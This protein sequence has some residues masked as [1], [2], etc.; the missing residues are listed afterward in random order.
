M[1][2]KSASS[3]RGEEEEGVAVDS[4]SCSAEGLTRPVESSLSWR[5]SG[6]G[7]SG[8]ADLLSVLFSFCGEGGREGRHAVQVS[9][10]VVC[11]C[12][13]P[14]ETES[15]FSAFEM[16]IDPYRAVS[17]FTGENN[18]DTHINYAYW[19]L[20]MT[21]DLLIAIHKYTHATCRTLRPQ[22]IAVGRGSPAHWSIASFLKAASPCYV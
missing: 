1:S 9:S 15:S 10:G 19:S 14:Q 11:V 16:Q 4:M 8:E 6:G 20:Q 13:L 21:R 12:N 2:A 17:G 7:G 22:A 5:T 3:W 18:R